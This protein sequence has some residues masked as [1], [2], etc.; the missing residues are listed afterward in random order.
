[1]NTQ[2]ILKQIEA[3]ISG[4]SR[5]APAPANPKP[6]VSV[7]ERRP[8]ETADTQAPERAASRQT[9]VPEPVALIGLSGYLPKCASV[10]EFWQ[11][12]E[13][14]ESL[15]EEIPPTRF[16]WTRHHDPSSSDPMKNCGRRGGFIPDIRSFDASFFQFLPKDA[17]LLDPRQRLLLMSV[18]RC[19]EDAGYAP[20]TLRKTRTGVFVGAEE[21]EYVKLA[22]W[23]PA[24]SPGI[25][26]APSM[27][28]NR[29]SY[30]FDWRGPSEYINAMCAGGAVAIHRA[31][32]SLRAGESEQAIV[33]VANILPRPEN[34]ASL[35]AMGQ[36]CRGDTVRSFGEDA[37]GY[38]PA[39][40]VA[41]L[42][43]K[44][45]ARA[46]ADG[47]AIYAVLKQTAVNF[48]GQ[49]GMSIAAPNAAV[50]AEL[51][52]RCYRE[53][54]IDP[55]D[56]RYIE[57]QGM[58]NPIT[59]IAE[60]R[61][62]N[63]ALQ[64][65]AKERG[66]PED[67][68]DCIVSTLKPTMGHMQSASAFGALFKI[69]HSFRSGTIYPI[70]S[71]SK[72]GP[73]I[74][75]EN[76][77]CRFAAEP[78]AWP[79]GENPRLAGLHSYGSG[80]NN[81]HILLEEYRET[82]PAHKDDG[83]PQL[84]KFS[85]RTPAL[86][87]RRISDALEE[88][89]RHPDY[90][91]GSVAYTLHVG[92]DAMQARVAFVAVN[93]DEW[94]AQAR[95]WLDGQATE[96]V[97]D[98][99]AG[100][101]KSAPCAVQTES[102]E[103]LHALAKRWT[104]GQKIDLRFDDRTAARR[105]HLPTYPFEL[106]EYWLDDARIPANADIPISPPPAAQPQAAI[107]NPPTH[108]N[109]TITFQETT[110]TV[111]TTTTLNA[112]TAGEKA[113]EL[114]TYCAETSD[115][116]F[117]EDYL[118]FCPFPERIPGF[119]MTR[120]FLNPKQYRQE[121]ALIQRKQIEMRQ[122]LFFKEDF[123]QIRHLL[124]IGCGHGTDVIQI[125]HHYPH[126]S[127]DGFTITKAQADLGNHRIAQK[128]LTARAR[129]FN[130]DS[131]KVKFPR[132]D[133]DVIIGLEVSCLVADKDG[134]FRNIETSLRNHG[135]LLLMDFVANLYGAIEDPSIDIYIP[136]KEQWADNLARHHLTIDELIDVSPQIANF[137]YDPDH[138]ENVKDC[139]KVVRDSWR[140]YANN[141][142]AIERG[143][144]SYMLFRIRKDLY[145]SVA[146]LQAHNLAKLSS[147]K[148][149]PLAL[150]EMLAIG[151]VPYPILDE[152][153]LADAY[154]DERKPAA[155]S[156]NGSNAQDRSDFAL[157]KRAL[158]SIFQSVLSLSHDDLERAETLRDLGITSIH[159]VELLQ[160]ING[161]FGLKLPTSA[162]FEHNTLDGLAR[163]LEIYLGEHRPEQLQKLKQNRPGFATES[164][165]A[166]S[167]IQ[168]D[169]VMTALFDLFR[170]TLGISSDKLSAA[171]RFE[172]LGVTSI[173]AV[174]LM[175]A[176]NAEFRLNLPTSAIFASGSLTD[177]ANA[178]KQAGATLAQKKS[179]IRTETVTA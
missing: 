171:A 31:V 76:Q 23:D 42:L 99:F 67:R 175:Q 1:M 141:A 10:Q 103:N 113:V 115:R 119:S 79:A 176:I 98:N 172:E 36:L 69:V 90:A 97:Y 161:E 143:W 21:N 130:H 153:L 49:G 40:G 75:I 146:D 5:Q 9:A 39:E 174:E 124:D 134:L 58:A 59:D 16:D 63:R 108:H 170:S 80:G 116:D 93:R 164:V 145:S 13:R 84:L 140:N 45:M 72:P 62:F 71:F 106:Q 30:F 82:Y 12:L 96:N 163:Y 178:L 149:Y 22:Q 105:V 87:R 56:L 25:N 156:D 179:A 129:I 102:T 41:S 27:I 78:L 68:V 73:D 53:A 135:R 159:S 160:A 4:L 95:A 48:N 18:Y 66:I 152:S 173:H 100:E 132:D 125:A 107:H 28:A 50:H 126:I 123:G 114:F 19:L 142:I 3:K 133:Y 51:I 128:G 147:A 167:E 86:C 162:I 64:E 158:G 20:E 122:V 65:L 144:L 47:D 54:G 14:G 137:Q 52:R 121:M 117:H 6:S 120:V 35:S 131:S 148:P 151:H 150:Q 29:I 94:I 61:A 81:A 74:D 77:V 168:S 109:N 110:M 60:W 104:Q 112:D 57:A 88:I 70:R 157:I 34:F 136:T 127:T 33:G 139:P 17:K 83:Q 26:N 85:A 138:E 89:N 7:T 92:R 32:M 118:T 177:L 43:L 111:T 166:R 15:L 37:D 165:P 55:R 155:L 46:V 101:D 11:A 154:P 91:L 8:A 2:D 38:L 169:P 44:P 24:Q